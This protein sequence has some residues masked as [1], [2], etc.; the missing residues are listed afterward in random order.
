MIFRGVSDILETLPTRFYNY[1][2]DKKKHRTHLI[3][4]VILHSKLWNGR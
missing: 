2:L 4:N 1:L 3:A